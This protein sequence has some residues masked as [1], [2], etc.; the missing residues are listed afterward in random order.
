[1]GAENVGAAAEAGANVIVSGTGIVRSPDPA[2]V[3]AAMR[4]VVH[5][6]LPPPA[7]D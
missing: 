7:G 4:S 3:I 5:T 6:H 2:A 1:M